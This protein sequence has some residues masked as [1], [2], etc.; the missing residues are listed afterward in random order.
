MSLDET[1][2]ALPQILERLERIE[3]QNGR[4][5]AILST[6]SGSNL[7]RPV[8]DAKGLME[9]GFSKHQSYAILRAYGNKRQGR[10]R[11]TKARLLE[12]EQARPN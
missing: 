1:L 12:Y 2:R 11:I 9:L 4:I 5:E 3:A 10:L 6:E 8:Y 7:D